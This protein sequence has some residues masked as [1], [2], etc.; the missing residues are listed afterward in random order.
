MSVPKYE[1]RL[2]KTFMY[3]MY[4]HSVLR[5]FFGMPS[6]KFWRGL[7][8]MVEPF[9]MMVSSRFP[10]G[11]RLGHVCPCLTFHLRTGHGRAAEKTRQFVCAP[12]SSYHIFPIIFF[13]AAGTTF[14]YDVQP[15]YISQY[16]TP[17]NAVPPYVHKPV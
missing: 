4:V 5:F 17:P 2:D 16:I 7:V 12:L 6:G 1:D 9:Q 8:T 3:D 13:Y 15:P 14:P 10:K 11:R